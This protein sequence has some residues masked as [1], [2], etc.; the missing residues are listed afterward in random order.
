MAGAGHHLIADD[1]AAGVGEVRREVQEPGTEGGAADPVAG[2]ADGPV[3]GDR[4]GDEGQA[5][6]LLAGHREDGI[7]VDEAAGHGEPPVRAGTAGRPVVD[8]GGVEDRGPPVGVDAG[9]AAVAAEPA[10]AR[11]WPGC[12]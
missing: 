1:R 2:P 6:P 10:G 11:R 12:G 7:L 5:R 8:D 3:A 4:A 9:P